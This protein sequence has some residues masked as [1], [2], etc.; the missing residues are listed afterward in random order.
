MEFKTLE[1]KVLG[2]ILLSAGIA[3]ELTNPNH[4][5]N[6]NPDYLRSYLDRLRR[7]TSGEALSDRTYELDCLRKEYLNILDRE[8]FPYKTTLDLRA[9]EDKQI[10][11]LLAL[12]KAVT[13]V[14]GTLNG[15]GSCLACT[16]D[17]SQATGPF[18]LTILLGAGYIFFSK[19]KTNSIIEEIKKTRKTIIYYPGIFERTISQRGE[20]IAKVLCVA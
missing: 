6:G 1:D 2:S 19:A 14:Y 3:Q 5:T 12:G 7:C 20:E 13:F 11:P 8:H 16:Q 17:A 4:I 9:E 15:I 10:D 18:L